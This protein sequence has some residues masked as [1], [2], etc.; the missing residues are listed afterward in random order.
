M[1]A[2][3]L[4]RV[5]AFQEIFARSLSSVQGFCGVVNLMGVPN[6]TYSPGRH[7]YHWGVHDLQHAHHRGIC[8]C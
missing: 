4:V 3:C 5:S 2:L 1:G 8:Y 6:P 7:D